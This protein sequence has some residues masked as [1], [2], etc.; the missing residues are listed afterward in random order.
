MKLKPKIKQKHWNISN[1]RDIIAFWTENEIFKFDIGTEKPVFSIDTP[2]PYVSG[3]A[4]LGFAI[5]YSQIDMIARYYRMLGYEVIFPACVDRNGLPVEVKVEQKLKKS[6]HDMDRE[7]FLS[8]CKKE[9]DYAEENTLTVM[10]WMGLSCNTFYGSPEIFYRTDSSNYRFNTQKTFCNAWYE[11]IIFRAA[12]PNN[13]CIDCG[14]TIADAE[15]EY[16][17]EESTLYHIKFKIEKSEEAIIIATT[18]PELIPACELII[19]NPSDSRYSHLEGKY[20]ITPFFEKK[21][22]IKSHREA[23]LEYGTGIMMICSYGDKSDVKILRDFGITN[24]K[25][26]IEPNG[27]LNELA[28]K[29]QGKSIVEAKEL[30]INDL[31][32]NNML[33]DRSSVSH[34]VPICW[35]SKTPI[36]II[37]MDEYYLEQISVLPKLKDMINKI[38]FFPSNSK[39]ILENWINSVT[40]DWVISRRRFYGTSIPIWYCKKC[41][42]PNVPTESALTRYYEA[43]KEKPPIEKCFKCGSPL[44]DAIGE[45]RT[46]DTWFDSSISELA[47]CNYGNIFF[48]DQDKYIFSESFPCSIRP[49]GKEIV[50]TWLYY[51]ILR[52]YHLFKSPPFKQIWISGLVRDPY[53][54]KMSKSLGNSIDPLI[55]LQPQ[56]LPSDT[57]E[58]ITPDRNSWKIIAKK[59]RSQKFNGKDTNPNLYYG[60]DSIR[61]TSCLQGSH[62]SDIRFS[63]SKLDGNA[64]FITKLWN[65]ARFI[66]AFPFEEEPNS[67]EPVDEWIKSSLQSL[68]CRCNQ[69][70]KQLDFSIPAENIYNWVW[71]IFAAH[72]L[73]LI[74]SRAYGKDNINT[75]ATQSARYTLHYILQVILKLLAPITPFITEGIYQILYGHS[76]SIHKELLPITNESKGEEDARTS[77]LIKLNSFIWKVKKDQGLSLKSSLS[78]LLIPDILE[79][80]ILDIK[81]MHSIKEVLTTNMF[82]YEDMIISENEQ[83]AIML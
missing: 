21:V 68:I 35:R 43:W 28:R 39:L 3:R 30:I 55:F 80:F 13:W 34:R 26:I 54:G 18:R 62:G 51:T 57:P 77:H 47:V 5:H 52:S 2:P 7:E 19:F 59:E 63:L 36:E 56:I 60:A 66:S 74:K 65:I 16:L 44:I 75:K 33:V 22:L 70:Y 6:M 8:I 48:K 10:K 82:E 24:P 17:Y 42:S 46:F 50:R 20:A 25:T 83:Y 9:L 49:Q 29:Y 73:E 12:H 11:G 64:K 38:E 61:L 45:K 78:L 40:I 14:T 53:G 32:E 4:H 69:G 79:E 1:E 71:N 67:L 58:N 27:K 37:A 23:D 31:N 76:R 41:D 15:I 81:E 72:Y